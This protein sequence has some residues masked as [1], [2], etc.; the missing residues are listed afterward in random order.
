MNA[1]ENRKDRRLP[2]IRCMNMSPLWVFMMLTALHRGPAAPAYIE[3]SVKMDTDVDGAP[4][5]YGPPGMPALDDEENAHA[6]G[7]LDREVV[8]YMTKSDHRTPVLQGPDDPFPGYYISTTAFTDRKNRNWLDPRKYVDA[9]KINYVVIGDVGRQ[10]GVR[11]G[12]FVAVYSKRFNKSAWAIVG[13]AGNPAG[14][15]G[16]LALLQ[17]LGYRV[18]DGRSGVQREEI[19][20]RYFPGSNADHHFFLTQAEIDKEAGALG[21]SRDFSAVVAAEQ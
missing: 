4:N 13:D 6:D 15:E 8:G 14:S 10:G 21:L 11:L 7:Q 19:V 20:I 3:I 12:D 17:S 18:R 1:D 16:S 2:L 5:A 9:T